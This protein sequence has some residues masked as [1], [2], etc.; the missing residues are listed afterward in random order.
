MGIGHSYYYNAST[1]EST[2][3]RPTTLPSLP[4]P[5]E[6]L[7]GSSKLLSGVLGLED[8]SSLSSQL[9]R[10]STNSNY[11]QHHPYRW[12]GPKGGLRETN[13][14]LPENRPLQVDRP[15]SKHTIPGCTPW[16]LVK[17]RLGRRF[18]YNPEKEESFWKFPPDVM[19]FV[20]EFDRVEREKRE[21]LGRGADSEPKVSQEII[22]TEDIV[23]PEVRSTRPAL[24]PNITTNVEDDSDDYEDVEVEFTDDEDEENPSKRVKLNKD[25][26]EEPVEFNEGDIAYQ[27]AAMGQDYGLDRGEYGD[28]AEDDLEEGAQ[29]LPLTEED[30]HAL[31]KDML[32]DHLINPYTPWDKVIDEGT[33]IEDDRYTV[34]PSMK[35]RKDVWG[36]WSRDKIQQ[37]KEEREKEELKDPRIQYLS[38]LQKHATPK[39]YWPEFRR[40]YKKEPELRDTKLPDKEREK[41]YRDYINRKHLTSINFRES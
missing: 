3:I 6:T 2:Y 18:V 15:K 4:A 28:A 7:Q 10:D 21:K 12:N 16:I 37:L 22:H 20:I 14:S 27:L 17:T 31:F 23:A 29:G 5:A 35:A 32:N 1:K 40:K 11:F 33:I 36:D 39:L 13:S 41:W 9:Y 8:Q 30:T 26:A 19:P 34:L 25:N 24:P 38:F